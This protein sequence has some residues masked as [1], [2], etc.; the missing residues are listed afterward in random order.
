MAGK[1]IGLVDMLIAG[2]FIKKQP[3]MSIKAKSHSGLLALAL[4][5]IGAGDER[6]G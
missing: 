3:R 5:D 4:V 2:S 6:R 1:V